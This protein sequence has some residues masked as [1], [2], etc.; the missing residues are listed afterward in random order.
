[1][2]SYC[3]FTDCFPLRSNASIRTALGKLEKNL[4]PSAG[5]TQNMNAINVEEAL[6]KTN[7]LCQELARFEVRLA[8]MIVYIGRGKTWV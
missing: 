5:N 7:E 1:M 4:L 6:Q 2:T 8:V 3:A